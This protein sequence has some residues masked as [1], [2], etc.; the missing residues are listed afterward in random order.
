MSK[1]I[2]T[3]GGANGLKS[4]LSVSSLNPNNPD[5]RCAWR[6]VATDNGGDNIYGTEVQFPLNRLITD[7]QKYVPPVTQYTII[8]KVPTDSRY[9]QYS[10]QQI[11]STLTINEGD[12]ITVPT[13]PSIPG[14]HF[15]NKWSP[16]LPVYAYE[17]KT[18]Y[19]IYTEDEVPETAISHFTTVAKGSGNITFHITSA[20][21]SESGH[22]TWGAVRSVS[23]RVWDGETMTQSGLKDFSD[24]TTFSNPKGQD[25]VVPV[26]NKYE[27]EWKGD[28]DGYAV[29]YK[30]FGT[31]TPNMSYFS[32][33]CNFEIKNNPMTL[34]YNTNIEDLA[35]QTEKID[36]IDSHSSY[37]F[38]GLFEGCDKLIGASELYFP[39]YID[40][41][42]HHFCDFFKDCTNLVSA[43]F[44]I[45]TG[46]MKDSC[47]ERMFLGCTSLITPPMLN[48]TTL[49]DHCYQA[50][51][52]GCTSLVT[53]PTLPATTLV[54]GCYD[55][56]FGS[57]DY[58]SVG[59]SKYPGCLN[60]KT[61]R[62]Y[63]TVTEPGAGSWGSDNFH[64]LRNW[65]RFNNT[66]GSYAGQTSGCN[67]YGN[68]WGTQSLPTVGT[69][70][71][72]KYSAS[73]GQYLFRG[74]PHDWTFNQI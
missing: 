50:M 38:C 41:G 39:R 44:E 58:T 48:A 16:E 29:G 35:Q 37:C 31:N 17:S 45:N 21:D 13:P 52:A 19:A 33:T 47:Y 23:Y 6:K 72:D 62:M 40:S 2:I 30:Q 61:I 55:S 51:F 49:G 18:Y 1:R 65:V 59:Y 42:E 12:T 20:V 36:H 7:A 24:W 25:I 9:G 57:Y 22:E 14:Y 70:G 73:D 8:F 43:G 69:T 26:Q 32:S 34:L 15:T 3:Y 68:N 64:P 10:G 4:K 66:S 11:G 63:G 27:I 28:A 60:L 53:A 46:S 5:N 74:I 56:M 67:F 71:E 54:K